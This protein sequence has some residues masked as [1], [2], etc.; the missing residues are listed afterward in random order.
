MRILFSVWSAW[1]GWQAICERK[2]MKRGNSDKPP[3]NVREGDDGW[4]ISDCPEC[5][6]R[7][8]AKTGKVA[9]NEPIGDKVGR[10]L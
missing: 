3:L 8:G 10:R 1:N 6:S 2:Q 7:N 5:G 9:G 4:D